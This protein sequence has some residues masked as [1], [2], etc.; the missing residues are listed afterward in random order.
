MGNSCFPVTRM[1]SRHL[2]RKSLFS[3]NLFEISGLIHERFFGTGIAA[4][5]LFANKKR[6]VL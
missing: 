5:M 4:S 1:G 6:W 2:P 3:D